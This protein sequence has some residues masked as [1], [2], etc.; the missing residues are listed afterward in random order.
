[1]RSWRAGRRAHPFSQSPPAI[2]TSPATGQPYTYVQASRAPDG[3][4]RTTQLRGLWAHAKGGY[5]HD[6]RF[7]NLAAVVD[8]YNQCF[9]LGLNPGQK[10]DLVEFLKSL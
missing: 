8:H 5:W 7:R 2:A 1:M 3:M 4:Y 9:K 10:S 6:G